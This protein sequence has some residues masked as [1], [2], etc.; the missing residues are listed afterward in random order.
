MS[1]NTKSLCKP[2]SSVMLMSRRVAMAVL[3]HKKSVGD[4]KSG[5]ELAKNVLLI[6]PDCL[7]IKDEASLM[8]Y[9]SGDVEAFTS[10]V[11]EI[12][13]HKGV[14]LNMLDRIYNNKRFALA[15]NLSREINSP[16]LPWFKVYRPM[17]FQ[18]PFS[19]I[20]EGPLTRYVKRFLYN[21][22][23]ACLLT[24]VFQILGPEEHVS[25]GVLDE[26]DETADA[27]LKPVLL[28][29]DKKK[30]TAPLSL[31]YL[32][33]EYVVTPYILFFPRGCWVCFD[34]RPYCTLTRAVLDEDSSY[35]QVFL[36]QHESNH[37]TET[38]FLGRVK[39]TSKGA[40]YY[41]TVEEFSLQAPS[42]IFSNVL[43]ENEFT[44]HYTT[45]KKSA[46][47]AG[48]HVVHV[49]PK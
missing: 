10:L 39:H 36:N 34:Q 25:E 11:N 19:F 22:T 47:L 17:S 4:W 5:W 2:L 20:F 26:T 38:G 8:A 3:R 27:S 49:T 12:L 6:F 32:L 41:E 44:T 18:T 7:E 35:G 43:Y 16:D 29:T 46:R 33:R 31:L 28:K 15:S 30:A 23:D 42:M 21:T 24:N 1:K 37:L 9:Y 45:T 13:D 14:V 48:T 40:R